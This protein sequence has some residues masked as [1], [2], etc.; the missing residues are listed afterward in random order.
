MS[1]TVAD[2]HGNELGTGWESPGNDQGIRLLAIRRQG[3]VERQML[4]SASRGKVREDL[5]VSGSGR[6]L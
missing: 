5:A 6:P 3:G 4:A 2:R 1:L